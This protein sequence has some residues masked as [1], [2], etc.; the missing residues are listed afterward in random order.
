MKDFK[1]GDI[2]QIETDRAG[3]L[4]LVI[5]GVVFTNGTRSYLCVSE[6]GQRIK[7]AEFSEMELVHHPDTQDEIKQAIREVLLSDE[8]MT[9]FAAAWMKTQTPSPFV[10]PSEGGDQ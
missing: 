8:F 2:V 5:R 1:I 10:D 3:S 7:W 6:C 9:A 4:R